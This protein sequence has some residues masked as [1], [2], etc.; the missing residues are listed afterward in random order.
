MRAL[1]VI[2]AR[3]GSTR[4]P[5]KALADINGLPMIAHVVHAALRSTE[6]E[7]VYVATDHAGIARASEAAGATAI[8]TDPA[9][10]SGTDRVAAAI[11]QLSDDAPI[12]VN[13]QGDEPLLPPEAISQIVRALRSEPSADMAT[14]GSPLSYADL[15][16]LNRVKVVVS[17]EQRALYFSRAPIGVSRAVIERALR[18]AP[19]PPDLVQCVDGACTLRHVGVYGFR[20]EALFK[21]VAMSPS[22]LE[23]AEGLEQLRALEA[24]MAITV[25]RTDA[26][27]RGVDTLSD[28]EA[29]RDE[30]RALLAG[31]AVVQSHPE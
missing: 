20:R 27:H 10:P 9:L 11:R 23:L 15:L 31:R 1:V 7:R 28:L 14:L 2:P 21:F 30:H 26:A 25:V 16:D 24:G 8:M 5:G 17:T 19:G 6:V 3:F 4:L 12:I 29:V 22:P 13:V 18:A